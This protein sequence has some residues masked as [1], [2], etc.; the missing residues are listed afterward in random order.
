M[1]LVAFDL[2]QPKLEE[3]TFNS[4]EKTKVIVIKLTPQMSGAVLAELENLLCI[5]TV[6]CF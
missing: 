4:E 1:V 2:K 5:F 6:G 3:K